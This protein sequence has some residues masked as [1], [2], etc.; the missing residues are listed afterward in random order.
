LVVCGALLVGAAGCTA[1]TSAAVPIALDVQ[2]GGRGRSAVDVNGRAVSFT[3]AQLCVAGLETY[4]GDAVLALGVQ[5]SDWTSTVRDLLSFRSAHAHPGH[6]E[7]G[8]TM[9]DV[10]GPAVVD[11]AATTPVVLRGEGISGHHGSATLTLCDDDSIGGALRLA[12]TVTLDDGTTRA[13]SFSTAAGAAIEG[14]AINVEASGDLSLLLEVDLAA[15][16]ARA[17]FSAAAV[18]AFDADDVVVP[19]SGSQLDNAFVRAAASSSTY[20]FSSL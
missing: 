14:I 8:G 16:V 3:A 10:V 7:A 5:R 11:L 1:D 18:S 12:G 4:E 9:G 19:A 15:F 2:V 20:V 6:Y 13:F 17:D